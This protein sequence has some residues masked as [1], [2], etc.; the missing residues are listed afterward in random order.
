ME[1]EADYPYE[2]IQSSCLFDQSKVK[3]QVRG[4]EKWLFSNEDDIKKVLHTRGPLSTGKGYYDIFQM[5]RFRNTVTYGHNYNM[6]HDL[7]VIMMKYEP[8]DSIQY[9]NRKNTEAFLFQ[10]I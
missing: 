1:T 10:L 7:N 5:Y 9:T 2:P 6:R 8:G 4:C 3:A